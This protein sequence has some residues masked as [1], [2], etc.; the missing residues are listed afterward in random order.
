MQEYIAKMNDA[1]LQSPHSH[2]HRL[3]QAA[4]VAGI[5]LTLVIL[6]FSNSYFT[7][8]FTEDQRNQS[9]FRATLFANSIS[10]T[11]QRNSVV[12]LVLSADPT[13]T[14]ALKSK[15]FAETS[16]RLVALKNELGAAALI[17]MDVDGRVVAA[18]EEQALQP[19]H[20]LP[21]Y[22]SR[23]M[24]ET[25]TIF[26]IGPGSE[27]GQGFYFSRR[28]ESDGQPL[29]VIAVEVGLHR[30]AQIWTNS[31]IQLVVADASG[32][33]ILATNPDWRNTALVDL[34]TASYRVSPSERL[35]GNDPQN[36]PQS[37]VYI[38]GQRLLLSEAMVGFRGW[39]LDYFASMEN[40]QARVNG[41]IALEIMA[42][43]LVAALAFYILSRRARRQ[44]RRILRE[45]EELRRL[46]ARLEEEIAQREAAEKNL[47]SAE[48]SLEQASKLAALGQM[49]AAVSHELNQP[50]AAMRTY[51]A[52]AKLLLQRNR[53]EEAV[54]S[55]QRIDDLIE[56]MGAITRQ[57][58]SFARKSTD[59]R[60]RIDVRENVA[61]ALSMMS[62]QL[63]QMQITVERGL[64]DQPVYVYCDPV[65]IEQILINLLRNAVD[66]VKLNEEKRISIKV[67]EGKRVRVLVQDNGPGLD[68]TNNLFEPFYTTKKPG[69]GIGLGLAISAGLASEM[70][71]KLL[72]RNSVS[73]GAI[74]E[75]QVPRAADALQAAE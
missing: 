73:G 45:S 61:S 28:I 72:A 38:G 6:W 54:S 14:D 12:P 35:F 75:L 49:S 8:R 63:G 70:G 69:E 15:Y 68:D 55:F 36:A 74:F 67:T 25:G 17:L 5:A 43:A 37:F 57:L 44:S 23:A 48:Q 62:P 7:D 34:L 9:L 56:R 59:D 21:E 19:N 46:N 24:R 13:L 11:L 26:Q 33:I 30:Q 42:L 41:I 1:P 3:M 64:P 22:F 10:S 16:D 47:Q 65:R 18:S 60:R 71:G 53:P 51:L 2:L 52:G 40:V 66:A 27:L 20:E 29:G 39:R 4:V 50:L 32:Q 31:N 58:K